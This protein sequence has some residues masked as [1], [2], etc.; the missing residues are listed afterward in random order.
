VTTHYLPYLWV[1]L[2]K[3]GN[4][5]GGEIIKVPRSDFDRHRPG[6][7]GLDNLDGLLAP[8]KQ[9]SEWDMYQDELAVQ[10]DKERKYFDVRVE[11]SAA[12]ETSK[13]SYVG[14]NNQFLVSDA[15]LKWGGFAP[16]SERTASSSRLE[17]VL[18]KSRIVV[19]EH[20][21]DLE[22]LA[23]Q[24]LPNLDLVEPP[25]PPPE[26]KPFI[27]EFDEVVERPEESITP[28]SQPQTR[29]SSA[30]AVSLAQSIR[31]KETNGV[32]LTKRERALKQA[33]L[34]A[35]SPKAS[36]F[37]LRTVAQ[38]SSPLDTP[39]PVSQKTGA[40]QPVE[41]RPPPKARS[42]P[43]P[44]DQEQTEKE[45]KGFQDKLW[46]IVGSKWF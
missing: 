21:S 33:A 44:R 43:K 34:L 25:P 12:E 11:L 23:D 31:E 45:R 46:N 40:Q 36:E 27:Y 10:S 39:I 13:P 35:R 7:V 26:P 14:Q 19:E 32:P 1:E 30:S 42:P 3:P 2:E 9:G 37:K 20:K 29:K 17:Q 41:T 18:K 6:G 16:P 5:Q 22:A 38:P 15:F 4:F 8:H 28:V 24:G